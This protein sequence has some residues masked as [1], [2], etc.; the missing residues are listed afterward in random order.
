MIANLFLPQEVG[1]IKSIPLSIAKCDDQVYWPLNFSGDYNVKSGYRLLM[2]QEANEIPRSS[3]VSHPKRIWK[4]VW[5]LKVP[6]R[7]NTLIS[8]AG[9]DALPLGLI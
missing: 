5:S 4:D 6:N 3:D 8:R 7:V 9:L 2:E 1:L